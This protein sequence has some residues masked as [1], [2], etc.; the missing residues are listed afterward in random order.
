MAALAYPIV[1]MVEKCSTDLGS[2]VSGGIHVTL[3][4]CLSD[5]SL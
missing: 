1:P 4:S 5:L 3:I 2:P